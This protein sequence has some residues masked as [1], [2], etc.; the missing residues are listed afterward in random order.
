MTDYE[1]LGA[2]YLGRTFDLAKGQ[3]TDDLVLYDAKDLT[4]HA[5]IIGMTGSGKTGLGI[6]LLE[7]AAMDKVPVIA[8]DPKGDLGNIL[9]TF[10]DL[11]PADFAP[12][13]NAQEAEAKGLTPAQYAAQQAETWGKGLAEWDQTGERIRRLRETA[14]FAIYTPGSSAGAPI[15]VLRAFAVPPQAIRDDRDLFR[16]RVQTTATSILAL[17]GIEADP[18]TSREHILVSNLLQK[19]WTDGKDLDLPG[20]IQQIQQPPITKIGVM[21]VDSVFPPK[22]RF[23]F[24]M[25]VNNILAAPGFE[26]WTEGVPLDAS[27]LLYTETGKPRV[28]VVSIA[29]LG[30]AERMFFVTMLLE[31]VIGWMRQQPGT[32]TLRAILYMDEIAGYLPPVANPASKAPF[33]TLLKQARAFGLGV[34]LATQNPVDL[35]YKALANAGTWFLGRLQTERDK[36]RVMEGLEGASAGKAFDR[37]RMEQLI[38]SL[39]KRVFLLHSVH[40]NAP[41]TFQTRWTM[42]YLAGPLTREQIRRLVPPAGTAAGSDR[43]TGVPAARSTPPVTDGG[44][45]GPPSVPPGI[46]QYH[47]PA[48]GDAITWRPYVLGVADVTCTNAKFGIDQTER[49]IHLCPFAEGPVPVDW[50]EADLLGLELSAIAQGV[51]EGSAFAPAPPAALREKSY[52]DWQKSYEK[53]LKAN[54]ALALFRS[55]TYKLLSNPGESERDFRIRLQQAA[56]EQRD[57]QVQKLKDRY[58]PKLATLQDRLQRAQASRQLEESQATASKVNAAISVGSAILGAFLGRKA[59]SA[60]ELS[61]V[62]TAVR[63]AGRMQKESADVTRAAQNEEALRQQLADLDRQFQDEVAALEGGFDAQAEALETVQVKPKAG[64]IQVHTVGL[65]W[66]PFRRTASGANEPA[67]G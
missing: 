20:L 6:G 23:A 65:A 16:E 66:A 30:D 14:D 15:S 57:A 18:L 32:G 38:A 10:P 54:Q 5:V 53:W 67:W 33:L 58:A 55:P 2:F 47:L 25:Q 7:E 24:A 19:A 48:A 27:R 35:D 21:D 22:D 37:A 34:V 51:P 17:L 46:P 41:V 43:A 49:V 1:K 50:T 44:A 36:A 63:G 29:H 11:R 13:V 28:S 12:W 39:G 60:S 61:R 40:E 42:S 52:A 64:G 3:R 31:E 62:G 4:T 45:S 59:V 8:I 26:A 9:L 56:R